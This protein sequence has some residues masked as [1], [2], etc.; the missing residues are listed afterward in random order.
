MTLLPCSL[1]PTPS[2]FSHEHMYAA[3][4]D[5]KLHEDRSPPCGIVPPQTC[6]C[7]FVLV[8]FLSFF[9]VLVF[10]YIVCLLAA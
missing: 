6:F 10:L 9:S 2:V 5:F 1:Y 4:P 7:L 3:P 8:S